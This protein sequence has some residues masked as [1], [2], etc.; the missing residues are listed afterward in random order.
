MKNFNSFKY[1]GKDRA[2]YGSDVSGGTFLCADCGQQIRVQSVSSLP[3]CPEFDE[4]HTKK[5]WIAMTG[6]GDAK[7]DPQSARA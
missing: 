7:D 4:S 3:P 6:Q 2:P 5:E 1:N